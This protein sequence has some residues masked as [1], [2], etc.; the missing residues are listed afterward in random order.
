MATVTAN[1]EIAST[2]RNVS[3]TLVARVGANATIITNLD[4]I[5]IA[6]NNMPIMPKAR[7][8]A[9]ATVIADSSTSIMT[10]A[11]PLTSSIVATIL[12]VNTTRATWHTRGLQTKTWPLTGRRRRLQTWP[13]TGR[14]RRLQ[15]QTW[16]LTGRRRR[17]WRQ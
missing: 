9:N 4:D 11:K 17:P 3:A 2:R 14:R 10:T 1:L 7:P 6:K 5:A 13:L 16:Q 15:A 8:S 12:A